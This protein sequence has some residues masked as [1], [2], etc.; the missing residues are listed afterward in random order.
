MKHLFQIH[1]N[2]N[3]GNHWPIFG[4][5]QVNQSDPL[6]QEKNIEYI[7]PIQSDDRIIDYLGIDYAEILLFMSLEWSTNNKM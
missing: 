6:T 5:S 1:M 4:G 7:L 3:N 2:D